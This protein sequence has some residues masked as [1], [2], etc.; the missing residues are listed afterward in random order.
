VTAVDPALFRT[1]LG[2]FATGVAV[3]TTTDRA[4][5]PAGMTATSLSSVSLEPPLIAVCVDLAAEMH[6]ALLQR[7]GFIVNLLTAEQEAVSRAFAAPER[8]ERFG[9]TGYRLTAGGLPFLAGTLARIEC[10]PFADHRLGDH[11]LFVG[12]VTGGTAGPGEPLL[13]YRGGYGRF[14]P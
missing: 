7:H 6:D 11:T 10:A 13:Y 1:L 8:E 4:G 9:A 2:H 14:Q 12:R 3:V 5:R